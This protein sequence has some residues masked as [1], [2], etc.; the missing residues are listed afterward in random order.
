MHKIL[1]IDDEKEVTD[2]LRD[3]L[4]SRNY[5]VKTAI[6]GEEGLKM[7]DAE[8]PDIVLLDIKMPKK[9]GFQFLKEVRASKKWIP[10]II[11]SALTEPANML[12]GYN[13]E[14]DYYITKPLNLPE[15]LKA[16]NLMLS[17]VP[18]RKK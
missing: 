11:I 3:F 1:V 2:L 4:S 14:A 15:I 12:K 16:V 10:V 6:D 18:L 7:F 13:L 17:L 9:D 8:R 5:A